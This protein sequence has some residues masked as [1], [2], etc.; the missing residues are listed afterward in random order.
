LSIVEHWHLDDDEVFHIKF[1][2]LALDCLQSAEDQRCKLV[3][4]L[5]EKIAQPEDE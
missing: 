4:V 2:Q 5:F 3:E 1:N